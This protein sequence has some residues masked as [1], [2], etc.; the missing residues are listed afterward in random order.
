MNKIRIQSLVILIMMSTGLKLSAQ[1]KYS[2]NTP[3]STCYF[4][5]LKYNATTNANNKPYIFII[6]KEN[7]SV[8]SAFTNDTI[9]NIPLFYN[10][11]FLYIPNRGGTTL[12]KLECITSIANLITSSKNV[13]PQNMF[14]FINDKSINRSDPVLKNE[15][16]YAFRSIQLAS[17]Q[18][19]SNVS[20][21][22]NF[23]AS[24]EA[25]VDKNDMEVGSFYVDETSE[26]EDDFSMNIKSVKTYFGAPKTF[27]FTLSG[28]VRDRSTGEALPFGNILVKGTSVVAQSNADGFFTLNKVPSDTCTLVISYMGY[29]KTEIFLNPSLPKK[30]FVIELTA[31]VTSLKAATIISSKEEV[32][33]QKKEEV[34]IIKMTPKKLEQLPNLGEK[35]IMRSFQLMPGVSASNES[36]SGLYVRGG[37]PD[38]N[39]VLYDGFA[40]YQVDH[41]YGFY[42]AFNANAIKDVQLYKGGFESRFGGRLSSVTEITGKD[43]N[44]KKFNIG[45]DVSLL[46]MNF[47]TEIPIGKKFSS[48]ITYRRSYKGFLYNKIFEKF[49]SSTT[50]SDPRPAG[51][52]GNRFSQETTVTSYFYDVN[53]KFTYRP[54]EK[55]VIS[56][57]IFNGTD[58]LDNSV[59]N[60]NVPSFGGG[61]GSFGFSSTDLTKYGNFGT[62]LKW[63]RKWDSKLYSNTILSY[64]NFFSDRDRSQQMSLIDSNG[65]STTRN[66]GVFENN[67]LKDVSLKTDVQWDAF[68]FAQFQA[69][70]FVTDYRIKYTYAQNDTSTVLDKDDH[71]VL[72]GT[73]LQGKIKF[74][75]D[76]FTFTP[77][78]RYSYF[79]G[80]GETY[81]EPRASLSYSLT[82]HFSLKSA[83][84]KYYQFANRMTREDIL[85]GSKEFWLLSN[86]SS[87]PVSSSIHYITGL[88]YENNKWLFSAEAYYKELEGLTEY[89]IRFNPSPTGVSYDENFYTGKGYAKGIEFLAQRKVG[90]VNGWISYTLGETKNKFEVYSSKYF[91]ANQDVT[92]EFKIVTMYKRRRWDFAATLVYATG[93]PYTAPSGAYSVT[94]LDGNTS[95]YFTV[96]SKNGMRLPDYHRLDLSANYKILAGI[97]GDRKRKE[98]GYIGLSLFNVY[99]RTNIWYKQYTIE[100]GNIIETNVNYLGFTPNLTLSF[101]LW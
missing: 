96:T 97:K 14:L 30:N 33:M 78:V 99:N 71:S 47:W 86:G 54:N 21:S 98:I 35:D 39:L 55:D 41:L 70:A 67:D 69:G 88:S 37:T 89:S 77:G 76:K 59:D 52:G 53:G 93:R 2:H 18:V 8:D 45:A 32:V 83:Y 92:N 20:L 28:V 26:E 90:T 72:I 80:S 100:D 87:V 24:L 94:L 57:S 25:D 10:Y 22:T 95:D 38:Q 85:S 56:L 84:G 60:S 1:N 42:S 16:G 74:Y 6:C 101:K 27:G 46:S 82:E 49:N 12:H 65:E 81:V 17:E 50:S 75:E 36:S 79:S 29:D 34:S 48:I 11:N 44:Q 63:G 64:S 51:P 7:E 61:N 15:V 66:N 4:E 19:N 40:V 23:K 13:N 9:R 73:Y 5:Y 31:A 58:K 3:G 91:S 43:G 62:S 68:S